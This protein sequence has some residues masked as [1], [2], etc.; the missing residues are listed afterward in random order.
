MAPSIIPPGIRHKKKVEERFD[1]EIMLINGEV[2]KG[3][4]WT[5]KEMSEVGR[6]VSNDG[7]IDLF[8]DNEKRLIINGGHV[9]YLRRVN[10]NSGNG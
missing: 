3:F 10:E 8:N 6:A 4:G 5:D 1:V 7:I 2:V 9:L